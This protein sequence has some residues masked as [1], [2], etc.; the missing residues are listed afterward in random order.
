MKRRTFLLT[1][2]GAAG[3]LFAHT[4]R[5][6]VPC[7]PPIITAGTTTAASAACPVGVSGNGSALAKLAASMS[8]GQWTSFSM[9]GMGASLLDAGSGHSITEFSARGHWDPVHKK[10]QYWGQG[11]YA[12]DNLITWDDATNQWSSNGS[13]GMGTI[14]HGYYHLALDPATGDLYLRGYN[15]ATVKKNPYGGSWSNIASCP[16]I[17]NQVAGALEWFT[18]LNS[19]AGGLTFCDTLSAEMW[20][21][22]ANAW[23]VPS[24]SLSGMGSYHNWAVAAGGSLYFGGGNGSSVMY[25]MSASGSVASAP[26]TP[27]AAGVSAGIVVRHPDGNQLLLFSQGTS[28][29]IYRFN[30]SSWS[31]Q[32]THQ[33][34]GATDLWFGVPISDYGILLFVAQTTSTD[35]PV[36]KVYK[37]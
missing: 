18:G 23:A 36:V 16:N 11:H 29:T 12:N 22:S 27:I 6:A 28:G 24:S 33:I 32:G 3:G 15:S 26:S 35:A 2:T 1:A 34:G 37:A 30:G 20:N 31:T 4:S 5:A 17:A 7:P 19:S 9:G 25:R 14:G 21:K 10:I 8:S 13:A